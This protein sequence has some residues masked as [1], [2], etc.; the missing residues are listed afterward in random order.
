MNSFGNDE[1]HVA[2]LRMVSKERTRQDKLKREG[3]FRYTCADAGMGNAERL[4]CLMEEVGEV[5][6]EVLTHEGRKL[7]SDTTGS[8]EGLR[9]EITQVA[10]ICV[11]WL[12]S[13][14]NPMATY[15]GMPVNA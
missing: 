4:A 11:A 7:A 8:V 5:A 14:C 15:E 13:D 3:R 12:E 10:A 2:I 6:Q 9:K 1:R